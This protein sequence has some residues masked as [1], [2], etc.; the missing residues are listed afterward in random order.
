MS[1]NWLSQLNS[2]MEF[3]RCCSITQSYVIVFDLMDCSM[4]GFPVLNCL[5]KF[6][7]NFIN[8]VDD[9]IQPLRPLPSASSAFSLFQHLG[10]FQWVHSLHQVA[11]V[12][13]LQIQHQSF[14][15]IFRVDFK[16]DWF[17]FLTVQGTLK[18]LP[19]HHSLKASVLW[20]SVFFMVQL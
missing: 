1:I 15:W 19:Q 6:V 17:D 16:T 14:W 12:L 9:G 11:K 3:E 8:L 10:L 20:C 4:L 18:S 13:E 7:Q 5:S 2:L